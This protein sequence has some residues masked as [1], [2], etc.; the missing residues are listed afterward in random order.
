VHEVLARVITYHGWPGVRHRELMKQID[1][2][3][4]HLLKSPGE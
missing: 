1:R 4:P 3:L 2:L